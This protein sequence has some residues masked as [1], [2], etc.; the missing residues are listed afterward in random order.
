[1]MKDGGGW[2]R[3][4]DDGGGWRMVE[5]GGRWWKMVEDGG[6]WW[7]MRSYVKE[8]NRRGGIGVDGTVVRISS[9]DQQD[10]SV[11]GLCSNRPPLPRF[12]E[13]FTT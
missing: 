10:P 11:V 6:R 8:K 12:D 1:M 3:M 5:D 13:G 9:C 7:K 4:E 2:R